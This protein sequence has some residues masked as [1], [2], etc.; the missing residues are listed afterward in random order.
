MCLYIVYIIV[1]IIICNYNGCCLSVCGSFF[2]IPSRPLC[3]PSDGRAHA[4]E[5]AK[6]RPPPGNDARSSG[7]DGSENASAVAHN[8]HRLNTHVVRI[9][10]ML[11]RY[12]YYRRCL[13]FVRPRGKKK[14]KK[15]STKGSRTR[16]FF[17]TQRA[18]H[19]VPVRGKKIPATLVPRASLATTDT[20]WLWSYVSTR[21]RPFCL[22]SLP[23]PPTPP[24]SLNSPQRAHVVAGRVRGVAPGR[25]QIVRQRCKDGS[26]CTRFHPRWNVS[27]CI[28]P[29]IVK[30]IKQ[31]RQRV[32]VML[33][34]SPT[35]PDDFWMHGDSSKPFFR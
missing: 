35:S 1:I 13:P 24:L 22:V 8:I 29:M 28:L 18:Y 34:A 6:R 32:H 9:I 5:N 3:S 30:C 23:P 7:N 21:R 10:R 4:A 25:I 12:Y 20:R 14:K 15:K 11:L 19:C 31:Q 26:K 17:F 33:V 2:S 16:A 27:G